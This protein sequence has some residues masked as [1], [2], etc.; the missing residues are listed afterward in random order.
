MKP[1]VVSIIGRSG[2]G[3]TALL[4]K[5][6][7]RLSRK[8]YRVGSIKHYRH[9]FDIDRPGKD[10]HRHFQAGA[11]ASMIVSPKKLAL[12]RRL[13]RPVGLDRIIRDHFPDM[14][15]VITEGFKREAAA[16]IEVVRN[17]V[18][19][20]PVSAPRDR[21][22]LALVVDVPLAGYPQPQFRPNETAKI[23]RFIEKEFL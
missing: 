13:P 19:K 8:G 20:T 10:S 17:A 23:V 2:S 18:A 1:P 22:L 5:I 6:I 12:V 7:R 11:A 21:G 4:V 9:R 14:D 16:K 3:K 15:L